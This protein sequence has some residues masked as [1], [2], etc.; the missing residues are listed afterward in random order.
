M[1]AGGAGKG[2]RGRVS[3]KRKK[4]FKTHILVPELPASMTSTYLGSGVRAA[5]R[6][7]SANAAA[8]RQRRSIGEVE[9]GGG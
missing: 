9:E 2:K 8:R 3:K 5:A 1:S 4:L 6:S 7:A